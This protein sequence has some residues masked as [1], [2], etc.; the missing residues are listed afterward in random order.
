MNTQIIGTVVAAALGA[1]GSLIA[2]PA[3]ATCGVTAVARHGHMPDPSALRAQEK[4]AGVERALDV[5]MAADERASA[6]HAALSAEAING[7]WK[8]T[9]LSLGN[10]DLGIPDGT[11]IDAGYQTWHADGTELTNSSRPPKTGSFCQ[12][13]W[14]D[15][16]GTYRLNHWAL[17]WDASGDTFA[18]PLNLKEEVILG[19]KGYT[20]K[21]RFQINQFDASG[22][23]L[24]ARIIGTVTAKRVTVH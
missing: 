15:D 6:G 3:N 13:V 16:A 5:A 7:L 4:A 23:N 12:G 17:G 9:F 18:G 8:F 21:G 14:I 10:T 24:Q 19:P 2:L 11:V 20:M 22:T 1:A